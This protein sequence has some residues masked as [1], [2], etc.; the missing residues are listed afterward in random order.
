M[1]ATSAPHNRQVAKIDPEFV[2]A[3]I[4]AVADEWERRSL[5]A[6]VL[7]RFVGDAEADALLLR[8]LTDKRDSMVVSVAA[9]A[10]ASRGDKRSLELVCEALGELEERE[11]WDLG[12]WIL[13]GFLPEPTAEATALLREI[14][15]E[16]TSDGARR[17][18]AAS[19]LGFYRRT[20]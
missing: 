8:L 1:S 11:D 17:A 6:E 18:A 16:Q 5:A 4:D 10:L 14:S 13:E 7:S 3:A 9:T 12:Q 20:E 15:V 2:Q 19:I